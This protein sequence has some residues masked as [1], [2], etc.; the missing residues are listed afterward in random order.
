MT[1]RRPA[2]TTSRPETRVRRR[3][4]AFFEALA[5]N[6]EPNMDRNALRDPERSAEILSKGD[7]RDAEGVRFAG[8]GTKGPRRNSTVIG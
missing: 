5:K 6:P 2:A 7:A 4:C 8:D 1:A 3:A